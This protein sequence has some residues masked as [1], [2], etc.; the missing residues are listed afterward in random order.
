M[1][2]IKENLHADLF[3]TEIPAVLDA[4]ATVEIRYTAPVSAQETAI[5]VR[6][7]QESVATFFIRSI[8]AIPNAITPLAWFVTATSSAVRPP[9]W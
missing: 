9:A 1:T 4:I 5:A 8:R 2:H 7:T 6:P 3:V